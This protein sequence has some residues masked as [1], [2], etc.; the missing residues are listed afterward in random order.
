MRTIPALLAVALLAAVASAQ[1]LGAAYRDLEGKIVQ[2]TQRVNALQVKERNWRHALRGAKKIKPTPADRGVNVSR[3]SAVAAQIETLYILNDE[4]EAKGFPRFNVSA[5]EGWTGEAAS[6][7]VIHSGYALLDAPAL[8]LRRAQTTDTHIDIVRSPRSPAAVNLFVFNFTAGDYRVV[9]FE[10]K[11][12]VARTSIYRLDG[13][14]MEMLGLGE[15]PGERSGEIGYLLDV[16]A[17]QW[18]R[19]KG[20]SYDQTELSLSLLGVGK[21]LFTRFGGEAL[22]NAPGVGAAIEKKVISSTQ[23]GAVTIFTIDERPSVAL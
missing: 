2:Y 18:R 17:E 9:R 1:S 16:Q 19:E 13:L 14:K 8:S 23:F 7:Y 4:W 5:G 21:T 10:F 22:Q 3:L 11:S 6:P 20:L 12:R 15:R